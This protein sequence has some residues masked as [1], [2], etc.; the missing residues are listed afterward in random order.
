MNRRYFIKNTGLTGLGLSLS[1]VTM[2][3]IAEWLLSNND[4]KPFF[5]LSLAQWSLHKAILEFKTLHPLDFAKKANA[6]GFGAIEYVSQLYNSELE[7][8][9]LDKLITELKKRSVDN[10]IKNVLIM[11]DGEGEL[12]SPIKQQRDSAILKH[13]KWVDAAAEL[14]CH[15]IRVN[16]FGADT[17]NDAALWEASSADGLSRLAKYAAKSNINVIVENHGGLS[18]DA[19]KLVNVIKAVNLKNC[20]TLPD[21]GNFCLK[22]EHGEQ[23]GAKC[24][25]EYDKYKGVQELIP[26]AH[27]VSAKTYD[28]DAKGNETSID[29]VRMLTIVKESGY[30]GYIGIEY[31]GSRLSEEEGIEATKDLLLRVAKQLG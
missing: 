19:E 28:F 15:A 2:P 7:K 14:G 10:G 11:I 21:F 30:S 31:E 26:F 13:A 23:W 12:A 1:G 25:E 4:M 24:I 22:R 17:E 27:G 16:L 18:S 3:S 5:K 20:G 6:L 9:S 29:Y 8:Q